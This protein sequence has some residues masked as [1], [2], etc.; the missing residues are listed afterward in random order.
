MVAPTFSLYGAGQPSP[1]LVYTAS[2]AALVGMARWIAVRYARL[3]IRCNVVSPAGIDESPWPRGGFKRRYLRQVPLGR[4]VSVAEVARAILYAIE[5]EH[6]SGQNL[7]LD[8]AWT[9]V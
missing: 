4:A 3:G 6:L 7:V 5:S 9:S 1:P 2:K 8:G